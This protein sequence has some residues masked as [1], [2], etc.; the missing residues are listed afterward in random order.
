MDYIEFIFIAL[1]AM[2][3]G[4]FNMLMIIKRKFEEINKKLDEI[5]RSIEE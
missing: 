1:L 4:L 2:V 3:Y 5:Q